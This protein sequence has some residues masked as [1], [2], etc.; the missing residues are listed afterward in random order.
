MWIVED[1]KSLVESFGGS[2]VGVREF[3]FL[4]IMSRVGWEN[5]WLGWRR[6]EEEFWS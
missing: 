2:F 3:C 1:L 5:V 6:V 4:V